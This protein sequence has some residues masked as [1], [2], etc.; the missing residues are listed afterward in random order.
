MNVSDRT[1]NFQTNGSPIVVI[2][3]AANAAAPVISVPAQQQQPVHNEPA[4]NV[5]WMA[6]RESRRRN[7]TS[8]SM[9]RGAS[10]SSA[11]QRG[12][13]SGSSTD[14][15]QGK[16]TLSE[17]RYQAGGDSDVSRGLTLSSNQAPVVVVVNLTTPTY[18]TD[19]HQRP[20]PKP[21]KPEVHEIPDSDNE[22]VNV[23][24]KRTRAGEKKE[25]A[26][27]PS[28]KSAEAASDGA[29]SA[30][31][32]P[33]ID[34]ASTSN[35]GV[36]QANGDVL[37]VAAGPSTTGTNADNEAVITDAATVIEDTEEEELQPPPRKLLR[38][39]S[40]RKREKERERMMDQ[41]SYIMWS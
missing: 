21:Q 25:R 10:K 17:P 14:T 6:Q 15:R 40:Q 8:A 5:N 1:L 20:K 36:P 18:R 26:A 13:A 12:H 16:S 3:Q 7:T 23:A 28:N 34:I 11:R 2:L 24:D 41:R 22:Q 4:T 35:K 30:S 31:T 33:A 27:A 19:D 29:Q 9:Y 38:R 32:V 37:A 39:A